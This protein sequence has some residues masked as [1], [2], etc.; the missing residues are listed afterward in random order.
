LVDA[1]RNLVGAN[2]SG[3]AILANGTVLRERH[4]AIEATDPTNQQRLEIAVFR[5]TRV[6]RAAELTT[7]FDAIGRAI[8][9]ATFIPLANAHNSG[10]SQNQ[11]LV[12]IKADQRVAR[13]HWS[14]FCEHYQITPAER[15]LCDALFTG[16]SLSSI[17]RMMRRST[18][19][20]KTQAKAIYAKTRVHSQ[21]ELIRCITAF[22]CG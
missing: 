10:A 16:T 12:I 5:A 2:V 7:T 19:T 3:R 4:G 13:V 17:A 6:E 11:A 1:R 8:L 21:A 15:Q 22:I 14:L 20:L 9:L 18:N